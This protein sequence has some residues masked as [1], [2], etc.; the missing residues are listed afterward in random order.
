[1]LGSP[2]RQHTRPEDRRGPGRTR[3]TPWD[4]FRHGA[5]VQGF[6]STKTAAGEEARPAA[7]CTLAHPRPGDPLLGCVPAEPNS[8]SPGLNKLRS[9][10][11][12]VSVHLHTCAMRWKILRRQPHPVSR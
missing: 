12:T 4:F 3:L 2:A 10:R 7:G 8:V 5:G 9:R 11:S 1:V 6:L